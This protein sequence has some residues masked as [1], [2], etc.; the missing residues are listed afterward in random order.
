[1][2]HQIRD[3]TDTH[4]RARSNSHTTNSTTARQDSSFVSEPI[5]IPPSPTQS[6]DQIP[7]D[8]VR[9]YNN[10]SW[11]MYN[12]I[13]EHRETDRKRSQSTV[14]LPMRR[15]MISAPGSNFFVKSESTSSK[16][17]SISSSS[18]DSSKSGHCPMNMRAL[19]SQKSGHPR[20]QAKA[21]SL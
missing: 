12:R 14:T 17:E 6:F 21:K 10:R 11:N 8:Q 18:E 19:R 13:T 9:Y 4:S 16:S 15:D 2:I 3:T 1:M 7:I 5:R 20:Y